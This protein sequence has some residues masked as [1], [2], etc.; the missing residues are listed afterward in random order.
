V[1]RTEAH[2]V[3]LHIDNLLAET[4]VKKGRLR[5]AARARKSKLRS[6]QEE[7]EA[8]N[9]NLDSTDK[10]LAADRAA[11]WSTAVE[12]ELPQAPIKVAEKRVRAATATARHQANHRARR[13][14]R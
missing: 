9:K 10:K 8:L 2:N 7:G 4:K 3:G 5:Q 13:Q 14:A 12:L 11:L 1:V 6:K